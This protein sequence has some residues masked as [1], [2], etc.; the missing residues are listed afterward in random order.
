MDNF[1]KQYN[2][3]QTELRERAQK[4]EKIFWTIKYEKFGG[5]SVVA[6]KKTG[7]DEF[8]LEFSNTLNQF[9]PDLV[10]VELYHSNSPNNPKGAYLSFKFK[11]NNLASKEVAMSGFQPPEKVEVKKA[12]AVFSVE[13]FYNDKINSIGQIYQKEMQLKLLEYEIR[14]KNEKISQLENDIK[15]NEEYISRLEEEL[16]KPQKKTLLAGIDLGEVL[17]VAGERLLKRNPGILK[18]LLGMDD[19]QVKGIWSND[20]EEKQIGNETNNAKATVKVKEQE[21]L[22]EAQK[23]HFEVAAMLHDFF[24]K[25]PSGVLRMYYETIFLIQ[26]NE[27]LLNKILT[28]TK[29]LAGK[30]A[31]Y[32]KPENTS[33]NSEKNSG[34]K[35]E[36]Q[37]TTEKE[38]FDDDS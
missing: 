28:I 8:S 9:S 7:A 36:N 29:K 10:L 2:H 22:S 25:V 6:D 12:D 4:G 34:N 1:R 5:T 21:N 31:E 24:K 33:T 19:Q 38:E 18:G 13:H 32:N 11:P 20:S 15:E 27:G 23:K 37:T 30:S 16:E 3:I 14:Q 26:A 35:T 17:S